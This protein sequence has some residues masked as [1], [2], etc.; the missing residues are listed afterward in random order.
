MR[1]SIAHRSCCPAATLAAMCGLCGVLGGPPDPRRESVIRRMTA[2]LA[3]RGPD[4]ERFF[5]DDDIALGFRRLAVIDPAGSAQPLR[6]GD[7]GP[8]IMLNGEIYNYRELR[9]ELPSGRELRTAGDAEVVL[10]WYDVEGIACLRRL[11]GMFALAIW[12]RRERTLHLARDRF[13][14]KPLYLTT[15]GDGIAF[16][17]E[18]AALLAG[19]AASPAVDPSQLAYYLN[20]GHLP[21]EGALVAGVRALPPA[22]VLSV[23][24]GGITESPFWQPPLT[25][26][27][28]P[29]DSDLDERLDGAL[30]AAVRRQ[31]VADVPLGVFLSGGLDSSTVA[32]LAAAAAPGEPVV[33]FSV[34]LGD[35]V[36][37]ELPWAREA[38]ERIGS[39]HHEVRVTPE[40]VADDLPRIVASA[41]IPLGDPTLIPTWYLSRFARRRVTVALSGEGADELFGGYDRQR[42]DVLADTAVGRGFRALAAVHPGLRCRRRLRARLRRPPS[43]ARYLDWSQVFDPEAASALAAAEPPPAEAVSSPDAPFAAGR[44]GFTA[45]PSTPGWAPTWTCSFPATCCPRWTGCRW[46][47]VS[48]CACLTSTTRWPTSSSLSRATTR[49]VSAGANWRS[50]G[51]PAATCRDRS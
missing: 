6:L 29:P 15:G 49:S 2:A 42:Y 39:Q 1:R 31:L 14:I 50:A 51:P 25:P 32:D 9:R 45:T 46:R 8:V 41:D 33:T 43:L 16:A 27:A 40:E 11:N 4:D 36:L 20:R 37:D 26:A 5:G 3:H 10:H 30:A 28:A 38:A 22:T 21:P 47:T 18:V 12:D 44:P 13:G 7:D 34:G 48:R 19:G 17:S 23:A 35:G 24:D